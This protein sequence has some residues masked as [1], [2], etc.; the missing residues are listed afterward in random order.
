RALGAAR[1]LGLDP[2]TLRLDVLPLR[3]APMF[4]RLAPRAL[5]AGERLFETARP[6]GDE[7][8]QPALARAHPPDARAIEQPDREE[9]ENRE[10]DPERERLMEAWRDRQRQHRI[11][12]APDAALVRRTDAEAIAPRRNVRVVRSAA[13]AGID[14][15]LIEALETIAEA[16]ALR[17]AEAERRVLD[18]EIVAAGRQ[19]ERARGTP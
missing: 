9:H 2:Q 19:L 17:R 7:L 15:F 10:R 8:R 4:F 12:I 16:N 1:R 5:R 18:L 6:L 3:F 13:A 11:G 14:P